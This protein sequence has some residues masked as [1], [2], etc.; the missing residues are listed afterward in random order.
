MCSGKNEYDVISVSKLQPKAL[1]TT[2]K[3]FLIFFCLNILLTWLLM[4][5]FKTTLSTLL[6]TRK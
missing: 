4:K 3:I 2:D 6:I 1:G 5:I